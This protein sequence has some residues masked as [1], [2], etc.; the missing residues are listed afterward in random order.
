MSDNY[1]IYN[2]SSGKVGNED[3]TDVFMRRFNIQFPTE[4]DCLE[5]LYR[6]AD[7][8]KIFRCRYCGSQKIEKR[9]GDR[10]GKCSQCKKKIWFTA[11]T[12]FNQIRAAR[13]WLLAI[14]LMEQGVIISSSKFHNL[15]D[16]AQSSALNIFKKV[17]AV[18]QNYMGETELTV[19]SALFVLVFCKR[20]RETQARKH[21][22]SEQTEM[23][24]Q[25]H[26]NE[27]QERLIADSEAE[28]Q[29][30]FEVLKEE[31]ADMELCD[32]EKKVYDIL[33]TE[34]IQVDAICQKSNLPI[35][36]TLAALTMLELAGTVVRMI[37]DHYVRHVDEFV[38]TKEDRS[39]FVE[40]AEVVDKVEAVVTF[41]R[42]KFHG[43]SRKCLQN[44]LAAYWLGL[45]K[46]SQQDGSLAKW[47]WQF[48][49]INYERIL[50]YI[51]PMLVKMPSH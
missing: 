8:E 23:E 18:A 9:Y 47:C 28:M 26:K 2:L 3:V 13:P 4:K 12:F 14:L 1:P 6:R 20:S 34:P 44:Y 39:L 48:G 22:L 15:A 45:S 31:R 35:G 5:E 10:V 29:K 16:I 19:P 11:G 25:L 38:N 7:A 21:P 24:K 33:T 17:T 51:S 42:N 43:I 49:P 27:D 46:S 37:G 40:S 36:K 32:D 41:I 30:P 50:A